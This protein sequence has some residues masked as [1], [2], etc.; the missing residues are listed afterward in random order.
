M[1]TYTKKSYVNTLSSLIKS[2]HNQNC[3]F[4]STGSDPPS[5]S[6][7][8][9]Q[10][11]I[12]KII[13]NPLHAYLLHIKLFMKYSSLGPLYHFDIH[14]LI[15]LSPYPIPHVKTILVSMEFLDEIKYSLLSSTPQVNTMLKTLGI[16]NTMVW[17]LYTHF[18]LHTCMCTQILCTESAYTLLCFTKPTSVHKF[19]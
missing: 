3:H 12:N 15:Q 14:I 13:N 1:S 6:L 2:T 17:K 4:R 8:Q 18:L 10:F 5:N 11:Q 7:V 19:A 9:S 16:Q